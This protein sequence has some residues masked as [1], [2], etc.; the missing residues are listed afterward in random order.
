MIQR[1]DKS[2]YIRQEYHERLTR[3]IQVIGGDKI[4]LYDY[5]DNIIEHHFELFEKAITE[6]YSEKSKPFF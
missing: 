4:P 1:G 3:I 6:E 5:L 2:V